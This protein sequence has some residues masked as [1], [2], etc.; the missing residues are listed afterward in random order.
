MSVVY[1]L[2]EEEVVNTVLKDAKNF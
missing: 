1:G 2:N